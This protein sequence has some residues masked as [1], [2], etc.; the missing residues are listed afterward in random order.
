MS[1]GYRAAL[2]ILLCC[3]AACN[4]RD[5]EQQTPAD[6]IAK[7]A[8]LPLPLT[9]AAK[10]SDSIQIEGM[11]QP[12]TL[13]LVKPASTIPF[14]TYM[15]A[16]MIAESKS[17]DDGEAHYFYA[18][19]AGKRND[20]AFLLLFMLPAGTTQEEAVRVAREFKNS[21]TRPGFVVTTDL[22]RHGERFYYLAEQYPAEYGDG[23]GPRSRIIQ[24]QWQW[25]D[26]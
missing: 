19:F 12:I 7:P 26:Q 24:D 13:L 4:E 5:S 10:K 17:I 22:R 21:R 1:K 6:T 20:D 11:W 23:F 15:P 3:C 9:P 14:V 16:D 18:N 2:A 8:P 25:L